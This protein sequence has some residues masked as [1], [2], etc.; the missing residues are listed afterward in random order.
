MKRMSVLLIVLMAAMRAFGATDFKVSP[1]LGT[2]LGN[3]TVT[4]HTNA[5][6]PSCNPCT[7]NV[8][9]GGGR[10]RNAKII[11][12]NTVTVTTPGHLRGVVDVV[13]TVENATYTATGGFGFFGFGG[14]IERQNYEAVL[15][16]VTVAPSNPVNG[17][18]GSRWLTELWLRNAGTRAVEYFY[19]Y[20][21]C[22]ESCTGDSPFPYITPL[23]T[24]TVAGGL[25]DGSLAYL[26]RGGADSF[27]LSFRV[28][29][30]SRAS[31]NAGTDIPIVRE[32][33]F[34]STAIELLNVPIDSI[35]RTALRIYDV[36]ALAA[37]D[38][39]VRVFAMTGGNAVA[40]RTVTLTP[41]DRPQA[42]FVLL[43]SYSVIPDLKS[44]LPELPDGRYRVEVI[45]NNFT[46]WAFTASTNNDTQLVTTVTPQ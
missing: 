22:T 31:D 27:S 7:V 33:D 11:D 32:E 45:P 8:T 16:P 10:G 19:G 41:R 29:D 6:L 23:T 44:A 43:S 34:R 5:T 36:D 3:D 15:I 17:A 37:R 46:G 12:R 21:N 35:T 13:L 38:A 9:F 20:P 14:P 28:R 1:S 24:V 4:L 18:N 30:I 39:T 26:Q 2:V 40:L 42:G 25:T